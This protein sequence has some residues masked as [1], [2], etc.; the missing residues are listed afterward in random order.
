MRLN[1]VR[2]RWPGLLKILRGCTT[3]LLLVCVGRSLAS[4]QGADSLRRIDDERFRQA[5]EYAGREHLAGKPIGDVVASLGLTFLGVPYRAQTLEEPGEEHL[6][7]DLREFDCTT[8]MEN[9]LVLA[10]CVKEGI[11]TV[12]GFARELQS[13]RYRR[14]VIEGYPSR[15]HY[16]TDWV[17]E[18]ERAGVLRN[19]SL[20]L[21]GKEERKQIDFMTTHPEL[22][23]RL[24]KEADVDRLRTIERRLSGREFSYVPRG[25]VEGILPRLRSGD[26]IGMVTP[27]KGID[28]SHTGL[29]VVEE[30]VARFLHAPLS[31]GRVQLAEGS[32]ADYCARNPSIAGVIVVRPR[33]P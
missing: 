15:L 16:F 2:S 3:F 19:I 4:A 30:G 18:N 25:K 32:L 33:E 10:R 20:D 21:G 14:G 28:V 9:M 8:F 27:M 22:Y 31:G 26:I 12:A 24:V 7:I 5:I 11:G 1:V 13:V 17:G 6:V 23:P 29:I